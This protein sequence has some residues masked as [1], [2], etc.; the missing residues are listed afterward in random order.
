MHTTEIKDTEM[1]VP[2]IYVIYHDSDPVGGRCIIEKWT[3]ERYYSIH[4][5]EGYAY[6]IEIPFNVLAE[7]VGQQ[8]QNQRI[9]FIEQESGFD[10][11]GFEENT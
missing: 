8:V 9:R 11:L 6:K 4:G 10:S 5:P 2:D 3:D 1:A 7:F